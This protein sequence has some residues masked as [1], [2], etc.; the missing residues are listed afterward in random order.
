MTFNDFVGH[1]DA[2]LALILN[3]I[4]HNCGGVLFVGEK[5]TG[6]STL[7]RLYQG[8]L[9]ADIPFVNL[10]LNA[11]EDAL[12]GGIDVE[13]SLRKGRKVFQR[14]I[15]TR[16]YGGFVYIDDV[17]LLSPEILSLV[18]KGQYDGEYLGGRKELP[19]QPA[20]YFVLLASMNTE[21]GYLSS[22]ILDRFG[23]CVL[24]E[25][26]KE[27]AQKIEVM[28]RALLCDKNNMEGDGELRE[29]IYASRHALKDIIVPAEIKDHITQVCIENCISGH[30]GDIFIFYASRA[31]TA[32]IEEKEV[33]KE[34]VD[35]VIPLILL[36]R[37]RLLQQMEEERTEQSRQD[38]QPDEKE[39]KENSQKTAPDIAEGNENTSR[40]NGNIEINDLPERP[41]ESK[42]AE[43]IFKPGQTFKVKRLTFRKDGKNRYISG[44]R[45]KTGSKG[46]SG[47]YIK[48]ILSANNDIAID[49]TIRAAAPYQAARGR[50]ERLLIHDSD[51]R[52]KQR[53]KKMGHLVIL[54]VDGSGS[55]GAQKRMV[56]TKGTVQSLL[57]DCYQKRDMVSLIV[58][59]KDRAEVILPPTSS[60]ETASRR[61]REIPVG[62]KTPLTAGLMETYKLIKRV[63][64]KSPETRFL[65][66]LVTD[67][68]A[69][70]SLSGT[71]I[72]EE[73]AKMTY[74]LEDLQF[75]DYIVI[76]TEH[77]GKFI[78][79]D[80]AVHIASQLGADYYTIDDLKADYLTEI[81]Q[82]KKSELF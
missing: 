67:G 2:K 8:L 46:K 61:L 3:A 71:P 21:E 6:K 23:M 65:V 72:G 33:T 49:A 39:E 79:T 11:T 9:S 56:E 69:N 30:R 58:F 22:H 81:V 34:H 64:V 57:I 47:R 42:L 55:M 51:I 80:L 54:L 26:L 43:E 36:H 18:L 38:N 82:S 73:I 70:Q 48:R 60:V 77:K 45:T 50:K 44:R 41:R 78:K 19:V 31:Y 17:N 37:K 16:T 25:S 24:C 5:G 59:R 1:E 15:F 13:E 35:K 75:T 66:V 63:T 12:L 32:F 4:D 62:G 10:P 76:D 20:S 53:E 28:K 40:D 74:L 7:A 27:A 14:G 29:K 52:F 68:R